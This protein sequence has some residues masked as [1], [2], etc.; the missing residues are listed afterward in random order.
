MI[1]CLEIWLVVDCHFRSA[2]VSVLLALIG[3]FVPCEEAEIPIVDSIMARVGA[4]DN[5]RGLSTFMVEMVETTGII[6]VRFLF[7]IYFHVL[8]HSLNHRLPQRNLS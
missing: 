5:I 1:T 6:R 3:S 4:D 8:N 7:I 2:G